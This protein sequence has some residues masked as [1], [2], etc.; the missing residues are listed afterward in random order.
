[1][2]SALPS[3]GYQAT[4]FG[5]GVVHPPTI[6][7]GP[8]NPEIKAAL[9]VAPEVVYSPIVPLFKFETNRFPPDNARPVG[10]LNPEIKALLT[11][12]PV[13]ALYSPIVLLPLFV[14]KR[15]PPDTARRNGLLNPEIKVLL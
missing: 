6:P 11:V 9:T 7:T 14:T 3:P 2:S 5:G 10:L 8:F 15:L 4:M 1:M 13:V 12:A